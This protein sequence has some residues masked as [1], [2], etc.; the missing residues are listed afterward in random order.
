MSSSFKINGGTVTKYVYISNGSLGENISAENI[1]DAPLP[2][3]DKTVLSTTFI[4]DDLGCTVV[5]SNFSDEYSNVVKYRIFK[6]IGDSSTLYDL[7]VIDAAH[8][9]I[10]DDF[11]VGCTRNSTYYIFPIFLE[12]GVELTKKPIVSNNVMCEFD[13]ISVVGLNRV[14]EN[15]YDIDYDNIW[16]FGLNYNADGLTLNEDKVFT[17]GIGQFPTTNIGRRNYFTTQNISGLIGR[18][19]CN[20]DEYVDNAD[21]IEEWRAFS[22]N[23]KLKL[24]RDSR[25]ILFPCDIS[26]TSFKYSEYS[27]LISVSFTVTQLNELKNITIR[28]K[29]LNIDPTRYSYLTDHT[30]KLLRTSEQDETS[31]LLVVPTE[32]RDGRGS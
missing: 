19:D 21:L 2:W 10:F 14:S 24:F 8:T 17:N 9:K 29:Q 12:N 28:S 27:N 31:C 20:T 32:T 7:G 30:G 13:C 22:T 18:I 6:T 3:T 16:H 4:K 26:N 1:V 5:G 23:G 25:G 11:L 15:V